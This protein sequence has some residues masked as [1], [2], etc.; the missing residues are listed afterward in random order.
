MMLQTHTQIQYEISMPVY[1]A[2]LKYTAHLHQNLTK[3]KLSNIEH[4][5]LMHTPNSKMFAEAQ[6]KQCKLDT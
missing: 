5:V 3:A 1:L 2:N 6:L 4:H